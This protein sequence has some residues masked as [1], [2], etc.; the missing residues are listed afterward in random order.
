MTALEKLRQLKKNLDWN[1][2]VKSWDILPV[3]NEVI[4]ELEES[5]AKETEI[6]QG[7]KNKQ[8]ITPVVIEPQK[9]VSD[10]VLNETIKPQVEE[11]VSEHSITFNKAKDYLRSI[12][13][14]WLNYKSDDNL[15]ARAIKEGFK[16]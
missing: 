2:S 8:P 10:E 13:A 1:L 9:I 12:K 7:S 3:L 14:K 4:K 16:I 15:I 11:N 6:K 5:E